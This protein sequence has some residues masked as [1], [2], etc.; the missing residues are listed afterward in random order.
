MLSAWSSSRRYEVSG[1]TFA[2]GRASSLT[3]LLSLVISSLF[4]LS[5]SR[6]AEAR[7]VQHD[8]V[9]GDTRERGARCERVRA[10]RNASGRG[11]GR[12]R[13]R[14]ALAGQAVR[15]RALLRI[16]SQVPEP[17]AADDR[18]Q[19]HLVR[20][21]RWVPASQAPEHREGVPA[22]RWQEPGA[23]SAAGGRDNTS[24]YSSSGDSNRSGQHCVSRV[25]Q[26]V[27][28]TTTRLLTRMQ[29]ALHCASTLLGSWCASARCLVTS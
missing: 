17:R 22:F 24:S 4:S 7:P 3:L 11:H 29:V 20:R 12:D 2:R 15:G 25:E 27:R 16:R 23:L 8:D 19:S 14:R 1:R 28:T 13:R 6:I 21:P 18:R 5:L 10:P 26:A 9:L